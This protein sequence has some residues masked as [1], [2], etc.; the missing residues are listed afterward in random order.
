MLKDIRVFIPIRQHK[1]KQI[2]KVL[3]IYI[4]QV[5][6]LYIYSDTQARLVRLGQV[7]LGWLGLVKLVQLVWAAL[8]PEI[9]IQ[10]IKK[11]SFCPYRGWFEG[12]SPLYV[13]NRAIYMYT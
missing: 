5:I 9:K 13:A 7:G 12:K 8:S 6:S 1:R 3:Y 11:A 2:M 4:P 10:P